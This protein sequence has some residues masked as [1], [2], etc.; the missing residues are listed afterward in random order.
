MLHAGCP[1]LEVNSDTI[2]CFLNDNSGFEALRKVE[3][4]LKSTIDGILGTQ[5]G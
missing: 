1:K 5:V 4:K 2:V 3:N